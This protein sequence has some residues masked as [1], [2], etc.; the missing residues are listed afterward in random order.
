MFY[1]IWIPAA[2]LFNIIQA[3]LSTKVAGDGKFFFFVWIWGC[4]PIW[5]LVARYSKNLFIDAILYD[6]IIVVTYS[7][8]ILCF[9]HTQLKMINVVGLFLLFLSLFLIKL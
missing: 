8:A 9:T 1:A 2:I 7:L 3:W 6:S 5:A 4:L